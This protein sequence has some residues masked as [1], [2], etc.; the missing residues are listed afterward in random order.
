[1]RIHKWSAIISLLILILCC[2][3]TPYFQ[4][5]IMQNIFIGVIS[6]TLLLLVTSTISYKIEKRRILYI[7][8]KNIYT[9]IDL[10]G[11]ENLTLKN[12]INALDYRKEL[13][14]T[15]RWFV[16]N[17]YMNITE[18]D[19]FFKKGKTAKIVS[20]LQET[21]KVFYDSINTDINMLDQFVLGNISEDIIKSH[22]FFATKKESLNELQ[23]LSD[24]LDKLREKMN[25]Y[26]K[27]EKRV[28]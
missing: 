24:N 21:L 14:N 8:Y 25:F 6:S 15:M 13:R 7:I 16:E 12:F 28:V 23:K 3:L 2:I 17:I 20:H 19:F 11:V 9:F 22:K 5:G 10:Y 27:P 26:S 4:D 1:M 18:V